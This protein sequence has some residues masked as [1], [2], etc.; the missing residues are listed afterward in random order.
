[1]SGTFQTVDEA[2]TGPLTLPA[3]PGFA[4][5]LATALAHS[6]DIYFWAGFMVLVWFFAG[7]QWKLP[8]VVT[9]AGLL[10]SEVVVVG[11]KTII[12]RKRPPGKGGLIYRKADPFSFPSGHAA[13]ATMLCLLAWHFG[14]LAAFIGIMI[15]SPLM[16][17]SRI[18]IGIH[19]VFDVA[20]G[21]ILGWILTVV[22]LA[23]V[24]I[25][26]RWV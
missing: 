2:L 9:T 24:P 26:A 14:P 5:V 23:L 6:G 1:V 22:L 11:I 21:V 18:A 4:R 25:A 19:Y 15:W 3:R 13:R 8:A 16:V 7:E 20:A 12:R 17:M 10:L